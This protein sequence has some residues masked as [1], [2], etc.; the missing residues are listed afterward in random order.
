MRIYLKP[1]FSPARNYST[2]SQ[3]STCNSLLISYT[4]PKLIKTTSNMSCPLVETLSNTTFVNVCVVSNVGSNKA[5]QSALQICC[6][7]SNVNTVDNGCY[8]YCNV[9]TIDDELLWS[10]CLS[11]NLGTL[12]NIDGT[13][14]DDFGLDGSGTT[15]GRIATTWTFP[16][17]VTT[18]S[19]GATLT[20]GFGDNTLTGSA[21]TA[22]S[23]GTA[24]KTSS[25]TST[26][27]SSKKA[28]EAPSGPRFSF[29]AG[30]LAGLGF[31]RFLV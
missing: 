16:N 28:S 24:T 6:G 7:S 29:W 17:V 8:T 18:L 19:S 21:A 22:T 15:S 30:L 2:F 23:Q 1:L 5:V 11:D 31:W 27:T 4:S 20:I 26:P 14:L 9:T 12:A 3:F 10:A 25:S 13:C